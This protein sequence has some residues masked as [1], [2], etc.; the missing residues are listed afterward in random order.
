VAAQLL[1]THAYRWVTN[2]QAGVI[3]QLTVVLSL[4]LGAVF[5]GDRLAPLQLLGS[6]LTL[7]GIIG[8]VWL[9]SPPRAVE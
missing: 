6:A 7:A 9:Q 8:V 2:L 5:L 1:M 4:V 3:M